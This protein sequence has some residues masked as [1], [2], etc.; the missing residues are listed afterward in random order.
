MKKIT[1]NYFGIFAILLILILIVCVIFKKD[2][3]SNKSTERFS[4]T[5]PTPV[6][7]VNPLCGTMDIPNNCSY[8]KSCK[9]VGNCCDPM[10]ESCDTLNYDPGTCKNRCGSTFAKHSPGSCSCDIH[11]KAFGD[12]CKDYEEKCVNNHIWAWIRNSDEPN[13]SLSG[14]EAYKCNKFKEGSNHKYKIMTETGVAIVTLNLN[15]Y[16][17]CFG[18]ALIQ[19]S[20]QLDINGVW[21]MEQKD[22]NENKLTIIFS[23]LDKHPPPLYLKRCYLNNDSCGENDYFY[24]IPNSEYDGYMHPFITEYIP[25]VYDVVDQ[26]TNL[27]TQIQP[28]VLNLMFHKVRSDNTVRQGKLTITRYTILDD[29]ARRGG[30]TISGDKNIYNRVSKQITEYYYFRFKDTI[31]NEPDGKTLEIFGVLQYAHTEEDGDGDTYEKE[32]FFR[33]VYTRTE[34]NMWNADSLASEKPPLSAAADILNSLL[35][36]HGSDPTNGSG[37]L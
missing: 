33:I 34:N 17:Q 29:G 23:L 20:D 1:F 14:N 25:P 12:C 28:G 31:F 26:P 19:H 6:M 10:P 13:I 8:S 27:Y 3:F 11:C 24:I 37:S 9:L 16:E 35:V 36:L 32:Y 4:T 7:T 2:Q 18:N 5:T 15:S 21:K 30:V 22:N